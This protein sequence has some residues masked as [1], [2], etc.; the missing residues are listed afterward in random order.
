MNILKYRKFFDIL[1]SILFVSVIVVWSFFASSN[2]DV[3][4]NQYDVQ[5]LL[6]RVEILEQKVK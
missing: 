6:Q 4:Q 1:G 3:A 5:E 2:T